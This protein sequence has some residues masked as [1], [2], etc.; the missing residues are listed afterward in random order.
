MLAP[1][2][3]AEKIYY[4]T[5]KFPLSDD[6]VRMLEDGVVLSADSYAEEWKTAPCRVL[7]DDDRRS[8][9]IVLT[10]GKYHQIKRMMEAVHNRIT[11]LSR[12]SFCG[13]DLDPA[14]APGEWRYLTE[15]EEAILRECAK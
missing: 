9:R 5:V 10:E 8:G 4:F 2:R 14:L 6:D 1:K 3:H 15:E 12:I 7:P 11:S 13:I